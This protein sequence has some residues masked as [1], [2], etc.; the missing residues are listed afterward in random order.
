M[1]CSSCKDLIKSEWD[2]DE[3][4]KQLKIVNQAQGVLENHE[5]DERLDICNLCPFREGH[6]CTKKQNLIIIHWVISRQTCPMNLWPEL[7][8]ILET[9]F[10]GWSV[11]DHGNVSLNRELTTKNPCGDCIHRRKGHVKYTVP[12][13][14][15]PY[16]KLIKKNVTWQECCDCEV[17]EEATPQDPLQ[18]RQDND[19]HS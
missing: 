12:P 9:E 7:E 11:D 15:T 19:P 10:N 16:C 2:K 5:I 1:G 18:D 13:H 3:I 17:R 6:E 14:V 8:P 4:A